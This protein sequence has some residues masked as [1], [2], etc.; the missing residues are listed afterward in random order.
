ML[1]IDT[2]TDSDIH[3]LTCHRQFPFR[4]PSPDLSIIKGEHTHTKQSN[5]YYNS[6]SVV[7]ECSVICRT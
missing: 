2:S 3:V 1:S 7:S 5:Q 4:Y 6:V